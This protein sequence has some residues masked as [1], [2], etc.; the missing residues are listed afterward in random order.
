MLFFF[1]DG[2]SL[3][4]SFASL[5]FTSLCESHCSLLTSS[6]V[7]SMRYYYLIKRMAAS[8]SISFFWILSNNS[9]ISLSNTLYLSC[10]YFCYSMIMKHLTDSLMFRKTARVLL[11]IWWLNRGL[12]WLFNFDIVAWIFGYG[13]LARVI[14]TLVGIATVVVLMYPVSKSHMPLR[15]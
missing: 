13:F 9:C 10:L 5:S 6:S 1:P 3:Y 14:Y 11:V 15:K 2:S 8:R 7:I 12:L 4:Q